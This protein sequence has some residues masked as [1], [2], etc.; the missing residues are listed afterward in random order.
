MKFGRLHDAFNSGFG[1][2][3]RDHVVKLLA[4]C[5]SAA[6]AANALYILNNLLAGGNL[7]QLPGS[8][9][10]IVLLFHAILLAAVRKGRIFQAACAFIFSAWL[11]VTY[12]AWI[13]EGV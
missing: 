4:Y 5:V 13:V 11:V 2:E 8:I 9:Y 3:N 7:I 10:T 1:L 6:L 12:Q